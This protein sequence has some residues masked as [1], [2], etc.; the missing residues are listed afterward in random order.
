MVKK[1]IKEKRKSNNLLWRFLFVIKDLVWSQATQLSWNIRK[2][3]CPLLDKIKKNYAEKK[4]KT[5]LD[6][7]KEGTFF[8]QIGAND[9]QMCD[10]IHGRIV[11]HDWSGILIEP[12]KFYFDKLCSCYREQKGL[13]FENVFIGINSEPL[14]FYYIDPEIAETMDGDGPLNQWANGLGSFSREKI[15]SS[16][17]NNGFRGGEY[18][19]N[20][21]KF[22]ASI[23]SMKVS[24]I[25]INDLVRKYRVHKI[26]LLQIDAEGYDYKII[27]SI[28]FNLWKPRI[29]NFENTAFNEEKKMCYKFL[30]EKGYKLIEQ[31]CDT[32]AIL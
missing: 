2:F 31:D 4:A 7:L 5:T 27:M 19:Q 1:Y 13:F 25:T 23:C 10:P 8:I 17:Q 3:R 14:D 18:R 22:M 29:I 30:R 9:G 28:D 6:S 21:P 11:E 15:I 24:P 12:I 26:D 20:I 32:L 16:I